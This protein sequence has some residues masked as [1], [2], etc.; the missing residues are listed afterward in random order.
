VGVLSVS[1]PGVQAE[2]DA[3]LAVKLAREANDLLA[4]EVQ[5]RTDRYA[6]FAHLAMQGPSAAAN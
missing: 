2:P 1:S 4:A 3:S 5:R 6:G